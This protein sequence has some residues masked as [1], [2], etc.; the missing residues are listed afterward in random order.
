MEV[1][2]TGG[3]GFIG[4]WIARLL[5]AKGFEVTVLVRNNSN[6]FRLN[7]IENLTI[8][9]ASEEEW[10]ST[11]ELNLKNI[12]IMTDWWGVHGLHRND[13][14]QERNAK[15]W[16]AMGTILGRHQA[17]LVIALG[18]QAELGPVQGEILE[19]SPDLPTT[20][21]GEAKVSAKNSLT[22][23]F[24]NSNTRFVWARAFSVYGQLDADNWFIPSLTLSLKNRVQFDMTKGDQVWSYLHVFD[25]ARGIL[26]V[27]QAV[28]IEGIVNIA[29][30][31]TITISQVAHKIATRINAAEFL[32]IGKIEYRH[33]QVMSMKPR[34]TKL[35]KSGWQ[36]N[37][38][39]D[40]GLSQTVDWFLGE[41]I[42]ALMLKGGEEFKL[43][44]PIRP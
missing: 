25:F 43:D 2:I 19:N 20:K 6:I 27:I 40:E 29:N 24:A 34:T 1:L 36:P 14:Q 12:V 41:K 15:R 42:D 26:S 23:L 38:D 16:K 31:E 5:S 3:S 9:R 35:N 7:G 21:Y 28:D 8:I 39:L 30:P 4:S 11:F 44:L 37:I 18:S 13:P 22:E 33:D 17:P 10:T 32:A